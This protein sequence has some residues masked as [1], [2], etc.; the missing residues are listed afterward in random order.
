MESF[1]K[2]AAVRASVRLLD[3][4]CTG[5]CVGTRLQI[6]IRPDSPSVL[7]AG[8]GP[9]S[10]CSLMYQ[11][12][13]AHDTEDADILLHQMVTLLRELPLTEVETERWDHTS[14]CVGSLFHTS[15]TTSVFWDR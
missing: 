6:H 5:L 13:R 12:A 4:T 3:H 8:P 2:S 10:D 9:A 1:C 11:D 7:R 15:D 14:S